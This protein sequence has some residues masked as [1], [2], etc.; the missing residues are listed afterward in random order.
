MQIYSTLYS[1]HEV[2]HTLALRSPLGSISIHERFAVHATCSVRLQGVPCQILPPEEHTALTKC[3]YMFRVLVSLP[4][5]EPHAMVQ[6]LANYSIRYIH[7]SPL[8]RHDQT[9]REI[10]PVAKPTRSEYSHRLNIYF[11]PVRI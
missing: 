1:E 11:L 10:V 5:Y 9:R 4:H 2:R 6:S 7:G 8:V 3:S